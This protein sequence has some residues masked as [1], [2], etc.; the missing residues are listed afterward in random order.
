MKR[1]YPIRVMYSGTANNSVAHHV[2]SI[3]QRHEPGQRHEREVVDG[4][5]A[6]SVDDDDPEGLARFVAR[7]RQK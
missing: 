5:R 3:D 6:P 7:R 1:W 2:S 4:A